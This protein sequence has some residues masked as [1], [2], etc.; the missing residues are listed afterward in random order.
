MRESN[1]I[2]TWLRQSTHLVGR[3]EWISSVVIA[4]DEAGA[5]EKEP[6]SMWK[7]EFEEHERTLWWPIYHRAKEGDRKAR[8]EI[9]WRLYDSR[10]QTAGD[11]RTYARRR[12]LW[13]LWHQE[14]HDSHV[15]TDF[16]PFVS[17]DRNRENDLFGWSF[18]GGLL[19]VHREGDKRRF[20]VLYFTL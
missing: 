4:D 7:V 5:I 8:R 18:A 17:T 19:G 14:Q 6:E 15:S 16:F 9:L 3:A 20:R 1:W 10:T 12:V 11:D 2:F 13:R